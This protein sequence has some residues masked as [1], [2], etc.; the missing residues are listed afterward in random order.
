MEPRPSFTLVLGPQNV[1]HGLGHEEEEGQN[2]Q[3][4]P[5]NKSHFKGK[6]PV[7][8]ALY[9]CIPGGGLM[10]KPFFRLHCAGKMPGLSA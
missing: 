10:C 5:S 8:N 3:V 7:N 4:M 2:A 6:F 9:E 1:K